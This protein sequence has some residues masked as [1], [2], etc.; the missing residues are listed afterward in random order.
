LSTTDGKKKLEIDY[1]NLENSEICTDKKYRD[2]RFSRNINLEK[3]YLYD[4]PKG[5]VTRIFRAW[6]KYYRTVI[7]ALHSKFRASHAHQIMLFLLFSVVK[8]LVHHMGS[9]AVFFFLA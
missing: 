8:I 1:K 3:I 9:L 7:F 2:L 5:R 4:G 6:Q